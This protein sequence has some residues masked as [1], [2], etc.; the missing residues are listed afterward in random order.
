M[1]I[2]LSISHAL[3]ALHFKQISRLTWFTRFDPVEPK[4]EEIPE[5]Q[6]QTENKN[7]EDFNQ[8]RGLSPMH[9]SRFRLSTCLFNSILHWPLQT[10]LHFGPALSDSPGSCPP[11]T[12]CVGWRGEVRRTA[13][14]WILLRPSRSSVLWMKSQVLIA[15]STST[16]SFA[17]LSP[18]SSS[19][20]GLEWQTMQTHN[21]L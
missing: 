16:S 1:H 2:Y 13:T 7:E 12:G 20:T 10:R 21:V 9:M 15:S 3:T 14:L 8:K 5:E 11:S 19:V 6:R 18:S 17:S 4:R